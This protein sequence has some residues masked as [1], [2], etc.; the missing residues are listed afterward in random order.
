VKAITL[1]DT[2]TPILWLLNELTG[3][4]LNRRRVRP[5]VHTA[6]VGNGNPTPYYFLNVTNRSGKRDVEVTHV[7][8][9]TNPPVH[10]LNPHRPLPVRLHYD[11]PRET[12]IE[13]ARLPD[14][15]GMDRLGRAR[16]SSGDTVHSTPN[17]NV[18]SQGFVA[19]PPLSHRARRRITRDDEW[20]D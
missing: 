6:Y 4:Y 18:P 10:I 13:V 8:F 20:D 19:D 11:E 14:V 2:L 7:W 1:M 17:R 12:C 15:P 5:Q 16:L 3:G 9:A